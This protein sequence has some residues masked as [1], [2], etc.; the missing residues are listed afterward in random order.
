MTAA[1]LM[2]QLKADPEYQA[3]RKAIEDELARQRAVWERAQAPLIADLA[4]VGVHVRSVWDLVN[5]P[6][7]YPQAL[8]VLVEHLKRD[9]PSRVRAGIAR[10]LAVPEAAFAWDEI[11]KAYVASSSDDLQQGSAVALAVIAGTSHV[12][13]L[14]DLARDK[15]NGQSRVLLL[16]AIGRS[17]EAGVDDL[18]E[19]L[20]A[21]EQVAGEAKR[22]IRRRAKRR[23]SNDHG[24]GTVS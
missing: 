13:E 20:S 18:L 7:V 14:M 3:K 5:D 2:A 9:Y 4:D 21:D 1:E 15:R 6:V 24:R 10:A 12:S 11:K 8:P 19:Q 16:E 22:I 23:G 17:R